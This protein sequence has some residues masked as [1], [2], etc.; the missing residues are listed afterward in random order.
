MNLGT[1]LVGAILIAICMLPFVLMIRGRK[2]KEKQL[3]QSV[4]ALANNH[5]C[6]ISRYELSEEF[7][8]GLDEIANQLFFFKK[9]TDKDIAQHVNLAEIKTCRVIKTA[10]G[11]GNK[12][13][14]FKSIDKLDLH[15]S[16][17]D[18]KNSDISWAFYNVEENFELNGEIQMIEK[19]ANII[20]KRLKIRQKQ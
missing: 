9:T 8:V 11:N 10:N 16:F 6:K 14:H 5:H 20:N 3:L 7:A 12:E 18:R 13:D 17:L 4:L 19:W 2:K 1:G 15:F